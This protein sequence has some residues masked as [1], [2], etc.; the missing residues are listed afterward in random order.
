[1]P[2][3]KS[4]HQRLTTSS[5]RKTKTQMNLKDKMEM[6]MAMPV[7]SGGVADSCLY[8]ESSPSRDLMQPSNIHNTDPRAALPLDNK[9]MQYGGPVPLGSNLVQGG[10]FNYNNTK[11]GDEGVGTGNSKTETFKQYMDKLSSS[12]DVDMRGG[13]Y[14]TDPAQYVAGN[15]VISGYDDCCPPAIVGGK[16]VFGSSPDVPVYGLGAVKNG[17][18][19]KNTRNRKSCGC[20]RSLRCSH[21]K[22]AGKRALTKKGKKKY[23]LKFLK[24][25]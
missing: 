5:S 15:P 24:K 9:F 12:L 16:L 23:S 13:G 21:S 1:M 3:R 4:K 17:G 6:P 8:T 20:S 11:C 18:G 14:T 25:T 22:R 10:G 2:V 7:Q 19:R